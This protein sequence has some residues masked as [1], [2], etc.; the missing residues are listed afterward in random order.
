MIL[1]DSTIAELSNNDSESPFYVNSLNGEIIHDRESIGLYKGLS[2][3]ELLERFYIVKAFPTRNMITP[4]SDKCHRVDQEGRKIISWGLSSYGYDVRL[5]GDIK[6]FTNLNSTCID[7]HELDS[8]C[9]VDAPVRIDKK[10]YEY[11]IMPPNSYLLGHTVETFD[12]PRDVMVVCV[13]KSTYARAGAIVNTTPI[14][15]GFRGEVVIEISN[16]TSLPLKIYINQGI[17]QFM[18]FRGDKPCSV[19]YDDRKGKYQDQKGVTLP[20]V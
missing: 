13:G 19:S 18:F 15:P 1:S 16:A 14:E 20:T 12:I 6:I 7:P 11:V 8:Q 2:D 4:F 3:K 17:S 5:A 9:Y 10:G